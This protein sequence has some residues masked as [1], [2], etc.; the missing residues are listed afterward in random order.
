VGRLFWLG[1]GVLEKINLKKSNFLFRMEYCFNL[2]MPIDLARNEKRHYATKEEIFDNPLKKMEHERLVHYF[3][4]N[5][6]KL[7]E[8][9]LRMVH[10]GEDGKYFYSENPRIMTRY[11]HSYRAYCYS[12]VD[13]ELWNYIMFTKGINVIR[14][15][16]NYDLSS[17]DKMIIRKIVLENFWDNLHFA[18]TSPSGKEM[19]FRDITCLEKNVSLAYS[20]ENHGFDVSGGKFK[21]LDLRNR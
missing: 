11:K 17:A 5:K 4:N 10:L 21:N 7:K 19:Q 12:P 9:E 16:K 18:A 14:K 6:W 15:G 3:R 8:G 20:L 13:S 2:G 1:R